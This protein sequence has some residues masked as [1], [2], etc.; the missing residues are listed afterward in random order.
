VGL[1]QKLGAVEKETP[2]KFRGAETQGQKLFQSFLA[3]SK[4][5]NVTTNGPS[6]K[7]FL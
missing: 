2:C 3:M 1:R 5:V 7:G 6:I 4:P